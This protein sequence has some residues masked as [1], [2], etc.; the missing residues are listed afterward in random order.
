VSEA[1][2]TAV[3]AAALVI[4]LLAAGWLAWRRRGRRG[5][6]QAR[7]G[8]RAPPP[9]GDHAPPPRAFSIDDFAPLPPRPARTAPAPAPAPG[10]PSAA[11]PASLLVVDDSAV[12][13]VK[14]RKLF[15][16]AGYLVDHAADG[17]EALL[18][19]AGKRYAV[20]I[21][22]LEMPQLNG[23]ELIAAVHASPATEDLPIV[24]IT[25]HEELSARVNDMKGVY[26]VFRKPWDD[27]EL[28]RHVANVATLRQR[29][30]GA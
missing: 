5:M 24:A 20:L 22:D 29:G 21:T 26:G 25:G 12:A 14:L 16:G 2:L 23:F 10:G 6:M 15:E 30:A 11:L 18:L 9:A 3:V 28:Q 27:R 13:R 7:A 19:I 4:V 8:T 17:E 1:V